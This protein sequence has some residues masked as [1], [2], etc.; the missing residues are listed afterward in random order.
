MFASRSN[1]KYVCWE[2][3]P[4]SGRLDAF[5]FPWTDMFIYCFPPFRILSHV[6]RKIQAYDS[7]AL[8][9]TSLTR[10][11]LVSTA[12]KTYAR[13]PDNLVL[14]DSSDETQT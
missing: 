14:Q 7:R 9:L 1:Y 11:A 13:H 5:T 12:Y 8:V 10:P 4:E 6:I 3:E 2:P